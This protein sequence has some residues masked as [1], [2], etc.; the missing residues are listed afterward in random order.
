M[1]ARP[2]RL[3]VFVITAGSSVLL[4]VFVFVFVFVVIIVIGVSR[5][6]RAALAVYE[7]P[8]DQPVLGEALDSESIDKL[9]PR[10]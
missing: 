6:H 5:R 3:I 8:V 2:E 7:A 1:D 4:V 9:P 10:R